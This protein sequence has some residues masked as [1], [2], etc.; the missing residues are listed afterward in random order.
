MKRTSFEL[1]S[2][3][4]VPKALW[5]LVGVLSFIGLFTSNPGLTVASFV[6]LAWFFLLLWRPGE[7]PILLLALGFQWLQVVTKV[8]NADLLGVHV[9]ELNKFKGDVEQAIWLSLIALAVLALGMRLALARYK[10]ANVERA[11]AEALLFSPNR[12]WMAYLVTVMLS[13]AILSAAR[14]SPGLTQ[15]ALALSNIKWAVYF[16]LAY[17]CFLRPE[18]LY[19]LLLAFGV[20]LAL[21]LGA[22]FSNFRTVFFVSILA[23]AASG[24]KMSG[25]QVVAVLSLTAMLFLASLAWT[26]I[27]IE[28]RDYLSGGVRAQIVT[29]GYVERI[30]KLFDMVSELDREDMAGALQ[31]MAD[32]IAYVDFFGRVLTAVPSRVGHEDGALWTGALK[33]VFMPRLLFPDKPVLRNDSEITNHYTGLRMAGEWEGTSIGIGYV[34][35]SYVDFGTYGMFSPMLMLGLLWGAMYKYFMTRR[36]IPAIFGYGLAVAVLINALYFEIANVKLL[37]G[38]V[39]SFLV[40]FVVQ[41]YVVKKMVRKLIVKRR[42]QANKVPFITGQ[43]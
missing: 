33:H 27:K 6:L 31:D 30:Q 32:R 19:L 25:K 21:G 43:A 15:I 18:R 28:Y 12:L 29:R 4:R 9:Q 1:I 34:A 23:F 14:V 2:I 38:V 17:V 40:A 26:A 11:H 3:R 16:M 20:E 37:G 42:P 35:E 10:T 39:T 24:K 41:K 22:Y 8:F 13:V 7:P 36:N 5:L